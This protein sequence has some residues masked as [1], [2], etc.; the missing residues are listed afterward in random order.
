MLGG[1]ENFGWQHVKKLHPP[2]FEGQKNYQPLKNIFRT[3]LPTGHIKQ[4]LPYVYIQDI[5]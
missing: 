4:P 5:Q 1:P 2:P 3:T